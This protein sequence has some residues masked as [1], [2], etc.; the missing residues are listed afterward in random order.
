[1]HRRRGWPWLR[2]LKISYKHGANGGRLRLG[3]YPRVDR[4]RRCPGAL[5]HPRDNRVAA[6]T[7]AK[8]GDPSREYFFR[9]D[10]RWLDNRFRV[11]SH[12]K[13]DRV[14]PGWSKRSSQGVRHHGRRDRRILVSIL[15]RSSAP[16]TRQASAEGHA[17]VF[18]LSLPSLR[19]SDNQAPDRGA[20]RGRHEAAWRSVMSQGRLT[21][22]A[23]NDDMRPA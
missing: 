17:H 13:I 21:E 20:E 5:F 14:D 16:R 15:R 7:Q 3:D 4:T 22:R 10:V 19:S 23:E 2:L 8:G 9:L 12:E 18:I 1:M 11:G 6:K